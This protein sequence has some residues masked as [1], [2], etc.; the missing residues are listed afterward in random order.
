[1]NSATEF[2][3]P[4]NLPLCC[5]EILA[6]HLLRRK[7]KHLDSSELIPALNQRDFWQPIEGFLQIIIKTVCPNDEWSHWQ[8]LMVEK[9]KT[10]WIESFLGDLEAAHEC[11]FNATFERH[12]VL[13]AFFASRAYGTSFRRILERCYISQSRAA[14]VTTERICTLCLPLFLKINERVKRFG[15]QQSN[16][17]REFLCQFVWR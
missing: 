10:R 15:T 4:P 11:V 14:P 13:F 9:N 5:E 3:F 6:E 2:S 17:T 1:M 7:R 8:H 16:T 12:P